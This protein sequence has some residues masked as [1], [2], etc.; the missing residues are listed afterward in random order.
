MATINKKSK[1]TVD[2][3]A[4]ITVNE[5]KAVR[6]EMAQGFAEIREEMQDL[7][8]EIIVEVAQ[9]NDRVITKLD[10]F[11]KEDGAHHFAHK[12]IDDT[13]LD[14]SNRIKRLEKVK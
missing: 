1:I 7:K 5:F 6:T 4:R 13:L 12:R 8:T 9:N 14:H 2:K 11:F 3:L 10:S